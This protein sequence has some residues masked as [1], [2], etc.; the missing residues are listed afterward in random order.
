LTKRFHYE[1]D[2]S[3]NKQ[4]E[5]SR[6]ANI[7]QSALSNILNGRRTPSWKAAKRLSLAV[8]G[9][10]PELWIEGTPEEIRAALENKSTEP[11]REDE[12]ARPCIFLP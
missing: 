1:N 4:I 6:A 10:T 3:M 9:T 7:S 12:A 11:A 8:P 5:I 2:E